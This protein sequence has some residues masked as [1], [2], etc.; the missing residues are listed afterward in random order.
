MS[1]S[2]QLD[3]WAGTRICH[4]VKVMEHMTL[5]QTNREIKLLLSGENAKPSLR[6]S[7]SSTA[8][9]LAKTSLT[10]YS[11]LKNSYRSIWSTLGHLQSSI[12][13]IGSETIRRHFAQS[14][15][16]IL[17]MLLKKT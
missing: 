8:C 15:M 1:S 7:T 13:S 3:N 14:F 10:T 11:R 17:H 5:I 12:A 9:T 16:Q 2:S 4:V 6:E